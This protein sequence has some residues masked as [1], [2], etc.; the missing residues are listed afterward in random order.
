MFVP[1]SSQVPVPFLVRVPVEVPIIPDIVPVPT[2]ASV[3]PKA[4]ATVPLQVNVPEA[5]AV[6]VLAD[7][8]VMAPLKVAAA[9]VLVKA[10]AGE[11]VNPVPF[12]VNGSATLSVFPFKSSTAPVFTMVP[13]ASVPKGVVL[14]ASNFKV[15]ALMVVKPVY[16]FVPLN[17][18]LPS[19]F[20]VS[21]FIDK[22]V[23]MPL[24][25]VLVP[26]SVKS[27]APVIALALLINKPPE[28]FVMILALDPN[29]I[30]VV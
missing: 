11:A 6:M 12:K 16:V 20:F 13:P 15:P 4:P 28:P 27:K 2:P 9:P 21:V 10:P 23:E 3:N 7:A 8:K 25:L 22:T 26:P 5:L 30:L 19:P 1:E 14:F 18:Q 24:S 29:V 17:F